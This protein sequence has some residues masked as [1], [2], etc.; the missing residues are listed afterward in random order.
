MEKLVV[1]VCSSKDNF[2]AYAENAD[3]IFA[4]GN[5]VEECQADV[6]RVI[7][8]IKREMPEERIPD[9]LKGDFEIEWHYDVKSWLNH[10]GRLLSLSGLERIT[11][12][13]QKQLS[14]YMHGRSVPRSSQKMKIERAMHSFGA[15]LSSAFLA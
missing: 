15:E 7:D 5:T 3:G 10:F 6:F 13:H 9:I 11:G 14:A 2:G 1:Y 12:V 8:I 4:A